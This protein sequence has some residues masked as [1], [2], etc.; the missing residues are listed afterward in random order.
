MIFGKDEFDLFDYQ[1]EMPNGTLKNYTTIT[2]KVNGKVFRIY[3]ELIKTAEYDKLL[4]EMND[5][6][7]Y[8]EADEILKRHMKN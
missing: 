5:A 4:K 3:P 1:I 6:E 2:K 8:K 7:A